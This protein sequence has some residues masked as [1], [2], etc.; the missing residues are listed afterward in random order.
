MRYYTVTALAKKKKVSR[1]AILKQIY[2]K[3]LKAKKSG[4]QYL[5]SV[6]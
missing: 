2:A 4:N 5:I 6:R 3:K 1:T